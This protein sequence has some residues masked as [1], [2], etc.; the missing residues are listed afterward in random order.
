LALRLP[1]YQG[2]QVSPLLLKCPCSPSQHH[3]FFFSDKFL[4]LEIGEDTKQVLPLFLKRLEL[5]QPLPPRRTERQKPAQSDRPSCGTR[6]G[7]DHWFLAVPA[8][9]CTGEKF[10]GAD[11]HRPHHLPAKRL[12]KGLLRL[13][14][15]SAKI[16]RGF[17]SSANFLFNN[18]DFIIFT[19]YNWDWSADSYLTSL[20]AWLWSASLKLLTY[21]SYPLSSQKPISAN[22]IEMQ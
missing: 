14:P 4:N 3:D 12:E 21:L 17:N 15:G 18:I 19:T 9:Q 16:M 10:L 13:Q 2:G 7:K 1:L 5:V 8:A 20:C 11:A 6:T 22:N